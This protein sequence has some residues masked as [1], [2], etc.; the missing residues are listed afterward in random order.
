LDN[1]SVDVKFE[2]TEFKAFMRNEAT[3][4]I[5]VTN[6]AET[7]THWCECEVTMKPPLSLAPDQELNAGRSRIG[8]LK[9]GATIEKKVKLYTRPN[10]YPDYYPVSIT[11]FFYGEDGAIE[12]RIEKKQEIHCKDEKNVKEL[13]NR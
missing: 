11:L 3:M 5:S 2:P 4:T 12:K 7:G 1:F 13:Q 6:S 10:N 8:I 9:G